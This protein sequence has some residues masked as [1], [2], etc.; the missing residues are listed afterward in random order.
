MFRIFPS[1]GWLASLT[2][3]LLLLESRTA[4][5]VPF[6]PPLVPDVAA[7][8]GSPPA[9]QQAARP[10]AGTGHASRTDHGGSHEDA[11]QEDIAVPVAE[12]LE[13]GE[14]VAIGILATIEILAW[15]FMRL[16][17]IS[18]R[19]CP[20]CVLLI[21]IGALIVML[22]SFGAQHWVILVGM[23]VFACG[24]CTRCFFEALRAVRRATRG[25]RGR[26]KA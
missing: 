10:P 17:R 6:R 8:A 4:A 25:L 22:G 12:A 7:Q 24:H 18:R 21:V 14:F 2:L 5:A 13:R 26:S 3:C 1:T 19:H 9:M 23:L 20:R 11:A 16:A 15:L